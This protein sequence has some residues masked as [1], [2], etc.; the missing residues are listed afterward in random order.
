MLRDT[1]AQS[2]LLIFRVVVQSECNCNFTA[3]CRHIFKEWKMNTS[4]IIYA[5]LHGTWVFYRSEQFI[6]ALNMHVVSS[7]ETLTSAGKTKNNT[8]HW[9]NFQTELI[10]LLLPIWTV[11]GSNLTLTHVNRRGISCLNSNST[12]DTEAFCHVH[13]PLPSHSKSHNLSYWQCRYM[14]HKNNTRTHTPLFL[15]GEFLFCQV[16]LK[17]N[18]RQIKKYQ[19][20]L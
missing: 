13:C 17:G 14:K 1:A 3:S 9:Q 2:L 4:K 5:V 19:N 18:K 10:T 20:I 11:L 16:Y 8:E 6:S 12:Q 7:S 15:R